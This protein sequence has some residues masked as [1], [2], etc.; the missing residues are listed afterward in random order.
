[1]SKKM[2][3]PSWMNQE[4]KTRALHREA[5]RRVH[6]DESLLPYANTILADW[7]EGDDHWRWVIESDTEEIL[8]WV[9]MCLRE[10]FNSKGGE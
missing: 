9:Q 1:M 2:E 7:P 8:D 6:Y 5:E 3:I 10:S 4:Q